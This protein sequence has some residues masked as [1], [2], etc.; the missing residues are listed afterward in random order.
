MEVIECVTYIS[1]ATE[2]TDGTIIKNFEASDPQFP[3]ESSCASG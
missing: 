1:I 3:K 2:P